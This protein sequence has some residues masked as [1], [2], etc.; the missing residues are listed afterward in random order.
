MRVIETFKPLSAS[1]FIMFE[2]TRKR[3]FVKMNFLRT[4][5][6]EETVRIFFEISEEATMKIDETLRRNFNTHCQKPQT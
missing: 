5:L 4:K 2:V 6:F 3:S 1:R